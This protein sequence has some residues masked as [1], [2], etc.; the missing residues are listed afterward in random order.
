MPIADPVP[1]TSG[2]DERS[3][4]IR[5]LEA[6][7]ARLRR[8]V[9]RV[10]ATS[11]KWHSQSAHAADRIAAAH[12]HAEERELAAARRVASVG[13]RL[14]EAESAAH[15]L[16]AEVDRLRKQLANEEQLARERQSAAEATRQMAAS[17]SVERQRFRKLDQHFRI[18][19][20]RYFRRHAPETWDEFDREIYGTYKSLRA[21][22]PTKNGRT[23]R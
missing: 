16:Q 11:R 8:L 21:S 6:E 7:N 1:A 14:A 2:D 18:L 15:L 20:G 3:Q 4:R 13:E 10:R 9:A 17:V 19:A 23:R 12:A 5:T 22:T